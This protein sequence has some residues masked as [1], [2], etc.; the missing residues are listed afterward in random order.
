VHNGNMYNGV[1]YHYF[2][3]GPNLAL[4]RVLA[5]E[6]RVLAIDSPDKMFE[7]ELTQLSP[8]HLRLDTFAVSSDHL[9][10][11]KEL[12]YVILESRGPGVP[13]HVAQRHPKGAHPESGFV[14]D[15]DV[16]P[17]TTDDDFLREGESGPCP[18]KEV[19]KPL[20]PR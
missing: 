3:V 6:T 5:R 8:T 20:P 2:D 10:E 1:I 7:R 9:A 14:T 16:P 4:K 19:R 15:M 18:Y 11:R 17:G 12:G 13:F